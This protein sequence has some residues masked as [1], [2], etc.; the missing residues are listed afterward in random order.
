MIPINDILFVLKNIAV[1][2]IFIGILLAPAY[3]S[4]ANKS[5]AYNKMRVRCGSWLFGWSIIG[6]FFALFVSMKK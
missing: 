6:W 5:S 4:C 2:G 3:L 1:V